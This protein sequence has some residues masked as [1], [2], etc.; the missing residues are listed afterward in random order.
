MNKHNYQTKGGDCELN[1]LHHSMNNDLAIIGSFLTLCHTLESDETFKA[2]LKNAEA[3]LRGIVEGL[4]D[5][6]KK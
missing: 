4:V 6:N 1:E 3:S 2:C 5:A